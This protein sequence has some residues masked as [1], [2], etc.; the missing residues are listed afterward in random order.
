MDLEC[1]VCELKT[2]HP[3]V[4]LGLIHESLQSDELQRRS[5][6]VYTTELFHIDSKNK[7]NI[8]MV[9]GV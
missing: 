5:A 4:N 8:F 2:K 3:N 9:I 1:I 7:R 6:R